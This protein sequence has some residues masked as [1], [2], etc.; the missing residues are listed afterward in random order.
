MISRSDQD[1]PA[2]VL[3]GVHELLDWARFGEWQS[4]GHLKSAV[5]LRVPD[6][7][8]G[9]Y[10]PRMIQL[11][12][13]AT[14]TV[15][16]YDHRAPMICSLVVRQCDDRDLPGPGPGFWE[17]ARELGRFRRTRD[18]VRRFQFWG[19][20]LERALQYWTSWRTQDFESWLD[21]HGVILED[22]A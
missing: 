3:A 22:E 9:A 5:N 17:L 1:W 21:R 6:A 10:G 12:R 11:L 20:E 8:M 15:L 14:W 18:P 7:E 2:V 4:Y 19:A 13:D 16:R